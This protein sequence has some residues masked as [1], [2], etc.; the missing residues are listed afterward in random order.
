MDPVQI[1]NDVNKTLYKIIRTQVDPNVKIVFG[2]PADELGSG[3]TDPKL[4]LFLYT[5]VEN[6]HMKNLDQKTISGDSFVISHA[7]LP[8]NLHYMLIPSSQP[9]LGS[10]SEPPD[11]VPAHLILAQAMAALHRN[12][13][14]DP[15]YFPSD[16]PL[17]GSEIK[18]DLIRITLDDI[19]KIWSALSKPFQLSV[20][21]E[22]S[23]VRLT[24]KPET[25]QVPI[26]ARP[27][28]NFLPADQDDRGDFP[29][30][31]KKIIYYPPVRKIT[32]VQPNRVPVGNAI[33]VVGRGLKGT[34]IKIL[35]DERKIDDKSFVVLNENLIKMRLPK[36]IPPGIKQ[37]SISI[38]GDTIFSEVEVLPQSPRDPV[39]TE[40]RPSSGKTGDLICVYGMN[41]QEDLEASIGDQQ[42]INKTFVDSSQIN[43]MIPKI[44][45]GTTNITVK[46][47]D[48][49]TSLKFE[50]IS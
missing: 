50:V 34:N 32:V 36:D 10:G 24:T 43:I 48:V 45:D 33:S 22:V 19:A 16:S 41:F 39:I 30:K 44:K 7:P 12:S 25:R 28:L 18:I 8:L 6:P 35:V 11:G 27:R 14:V 3:D 46:I 47:G 5:I 4:H 29:I 37:I 38:D 40:V 42:I 23:I 15:K 13:V 26:V 20:C 49:T 9:V 21:Y 1:V 17:I 31:D 2:S